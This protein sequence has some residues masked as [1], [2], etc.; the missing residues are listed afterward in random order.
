MWQRIAT[1]RY[2]LD[3]PGPVRLPRSKVHEQGSIMSLTRYRYFEKVARLGSIREAADILHVAPS[4]ISRQI[5]HLEQEY[6]VELFERQARGMRLTPA[7]QVVLESARVLLDSI[8]QARSSIDDLHGL[9][10]G[11]IRIWTVEG[12]VNDFVYPVLSAF[13]EA[14]PAVTFD[15]MIASSDQLVQRLLE[16]DADLAIAFNPPTHRNIIALAEISDPLVLIAHPDHEAASRKTLTL[17]EASHWRLA[18]PDATFGMRHLIDQAAA[19]AKLELLPVLMTN[20]VES[21]RSFARVGMGVTLL[22]SLAV[23]RDVELGRLVIVPMKDRRLKSARV[24]ICVRRDRHLPAAARALARAFEQNARKVVITPSFS[25]AGSAT[26][27][28]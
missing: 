20:S 17:T 7:G 25:V 26:A 5:A 27:L 10:R 28:A 8:D 1:L 2:S 3:I 24:K 9:R 16:D 22:T 21:L 12:M 11:H 15:L 4:A 6:D 23:R 14:H 13:G 19:A 18:L